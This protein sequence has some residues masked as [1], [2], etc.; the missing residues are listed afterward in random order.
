MRSEFR[1]DR[2]G[3][4]SAKAA[5]LGRL[6]HPTGAPAAAG[7]PVSR[8][9]EVAQKLAASLSSASSWTCSSAASASPSAL[10]DPVVLP[11]PV[12]LQLRL[13]LHVLG[14]DRDLRPAPAPRGSSTGPASA[15]RP[16]APPGP[17]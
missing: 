3:W 15:A 13:E 16:P 5:L 2:Q 17:S 12:L 8:V 9:S 11:V 4:E 10:G 6:R 7:A 14:H 1:H